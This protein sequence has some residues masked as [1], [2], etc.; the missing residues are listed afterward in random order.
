MLVSYHTLRG[1]LMNL[2]KMHRLLVFR[3]TVSA[4]AYVDPRSLLGCWATHRVSV[5]DIVAPADCCALCIDIVVFLR[6]QLAKGG[7]T[8]ASWNALGLCSSAHRVYPPR[9]PWEGVAKGVAS[10]SKPHWEATLDPNDSGL[11]TGKGQ[12]EYRKGSQLTNC[13]HRVAMITQHTLAAIANLLA[14]LAVI[15]AVGY[16]VVAVK[17]R[18]AER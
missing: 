4:I 1:I 3:P 8:L 7:K 9:K 6:H 13:I 14:I 2:R 5:C 18:P 16:H 11:L 17:L 10:P 12:P 15:L